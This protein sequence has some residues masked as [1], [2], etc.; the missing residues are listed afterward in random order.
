MTRQLRN[1]RV[2]ADRTLIRRYVLALPPTGAGNAGNEAAVTATSVPPLSGG[3]CSH[4]SAATHAFTITD[5]VGGG[6]NALPGPGWRVSLVGSPH[7]AAQLFGEE[8]RCSFTFR[9]LR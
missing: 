5:S 9:R 4:G 2:T 1:T 6:G 8:A 3:P 7:G